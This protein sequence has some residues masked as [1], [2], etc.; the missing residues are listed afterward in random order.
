MTNNIFEG[1]YTTHRKP[2]KGF[3]V[4]VLCIEYLPARKPTQTTHHSVTPMST[5]SRS[6]IVKKIIMTIAPGIQGFFDLYGRKYL[7]AVVKMPSQTQIGRFQDVFDGPVI[8]ELDKYPRRYDLV[9]RAKVNFCIEHK[10]DTGV[11][12]TQ[13][14]H[15]I[16]KG[17]VVYPGGI[18]M[19]GLIVGTS[20]G[21]PPADIAAARMIAAA[22]TGYAQMAMERLLAEAEA[23]GSYQA[24]RDAL[25]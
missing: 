24:P 12:L 9:A 10:M 5:E 16:S 11:A 23:N 20:G 17:D 6:D 8:G 14:A 3:R 19:D 18:Y 21:P 22:I 4:E 25:S 15:L 7:H 1:I 2:K 13:A